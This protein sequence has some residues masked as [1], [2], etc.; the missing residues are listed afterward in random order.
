MNKLLKAIISVFTIFLFN[1]SFSFAFNA[2]DRVSVDVNG[3]QGDG[4][5]YDPN[6]SSDG[7]FVTFSSDATNLVSGDSNGSS[8]IFVY[9]RDNN[10]IERVSVDTNGNQGN[11]SSYDPNISPDGHFVV[12][13]SL[14]TNLVSGDTNSVFDIF[15]YD[16]TNNTIERVSIDANGNQGNANSF[17]PDISSD[18]RF[19]SFFSAATNLVAG[20]TNNFYDVFVYD[21]TN[22]TIE[23]VSVDANGNQGDSVSYSSSIS[24]DGRFVTFLSIS[25]NLVPGDLNGQQDVFV[26]DRTNNTIG[27]VSVDANGN[28]GDNG[29]Y[30]P[31][32]SSDGRFVTFSSD[33]TNLVAGDT[34]NKRDI[35]VYDR[36]NNTIERVSVDANG[37]EGD[38][39]SLLGSI[40]SDGKFVTFSSDATNLVARDTNNFRD[41]FLRYTEV[42]QA[43]QINFRSS[44]KSHVRFAC[45]DKKASNYSKFGQHKQSVCRYEDVETP[46]EDNPL[47]GK[48]CPQNLTIHNFMKKGDRDGKYSS[49]NKGRVREVKLLQ[50]HINRI[51][52]NEYTE[53][54]AGPED[55]IFG[56]LTER[57]VKRLQTKLNKLLKG[58]I[59]KPLIVDG[60]VGPYTREAINHSC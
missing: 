37:N 42:P 49:Y 27:R 19:V 15:V 34:N 9:N 18:G 5:S 48:L 53:K 47:G 38:D 41:I 16:R 46:T 58:I 25:T 59:K 56:T 33:A 11:A 30:Y 20:D 54:P 29:S 28:E 32:I 35:F 7:R 43:Q 55:G 12:F 26:Y 6:I 17:N 1:Y 36:T 23:R 44:K 8:D 39:D 45:K 2:I 50:S 60:I 57:G 13:Q 4:S 14:S 24:S 40:S 10:T 3:N 22:N 52:K 51:L 21:R 31:N